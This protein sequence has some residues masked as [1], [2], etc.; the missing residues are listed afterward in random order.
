LF[1]TTAG[2]LP[3]FTAASGAACRRRRCAILLAHLLD[4]LTVALSEVLIL[5][6]AFGLAH[7][8]P[9]TI[10]FVVRHGSFSLRV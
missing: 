10:L 1:A 6:A 3:Q 7:R 8:I 4:Q 2:H 5:T 9:K